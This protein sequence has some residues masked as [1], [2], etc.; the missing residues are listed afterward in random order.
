LIPEP[1]IECSAVNASLSAGD[2]G[3]WRERKQRFDGCRTGGWAVQLQRLLGMKADRTAD[4][5][6]AGHAAKGGKVS[7]TGSDGQRDQVHTYGSFYGENGKKTIYQ[8]R[9]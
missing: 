6:R 8:T 7:A 4:S 5:R 1:R 3:E 2:N 9:N